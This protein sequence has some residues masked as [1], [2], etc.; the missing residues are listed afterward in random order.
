LNGINGPDVI[1][2]ILSNILKFLKTSLK[3]RLV[4]LQAIGIKGIIYQQGV[5][6]SIFQTGVMLPSCSA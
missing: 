4:G 6:N 1:G 2:S 3:I 5:E